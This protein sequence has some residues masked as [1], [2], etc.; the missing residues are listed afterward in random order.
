M[1]ASDLRIGDIVGVCYE[2]ILIADQV[3]ILEPGVVH[4]SSRKNP[5]S[6]RDIVGVP[7]QEEWLRKFNFKYNSHSEE[8]KF[9]EIII[10]KIQSE[11]MNMWL[12]QS[13]TL[14]LKIAFV[15]QLQDLLHVLGQSN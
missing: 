12:V 10:K 4:L 3:I 15:H 6:D 13:E 2:D 7:L 14:Q 8:W 11:K 9:D 1:K 5:D